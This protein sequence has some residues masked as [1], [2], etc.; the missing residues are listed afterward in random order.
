MQIEDQEAPKKSG[1]LAGRRCIPL[2]EAL[3]KIK[4]AVQARDEIDPSFVICARCD[5][6]GAEGGTFASTSQSAASPTCAT[7]GLTSCGSTPCNR[8][9]N[10]ASCVAKCRVRCWR[11]GAAQLESRA[12]DRR[13]RRARRAHRTVS[14]LDGDLRLAGRLGTAQRFLRARHAGARPSAQRAPARAVSGAARHSGTSSI[15]TA[16]G[17]SKELLPAAQKRDYENLRG[18]R[19]LAKKK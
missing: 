2:D 3:G 16:F 9:T 18:T 7:A 14:D 17:N 4:A 19:P 5:E 6:L 11:S 15:T 12:D 10:C 8:A 13:V 1:T